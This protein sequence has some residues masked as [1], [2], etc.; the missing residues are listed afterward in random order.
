[1]KSS[2]ILD[3]IVLALIVGTAGMLAGAPTAA[4]AQDL[5]ISQSPLFVATNVEPNVMF[6]LDDSGSMQWEYMPDGPEFRFTIF[7]FPRPAGLY[8]GTN[9]A[10]QVPS[11]RDDNI[12]HLYARSA[13][14]NGVFY[15]PDITYRPWSRPDG[16]DMPPAD[17]ENALYNPDI[18]G[19]GGLNLTVPQTQEA[20]WFRGNAL[21]QGFCDGA[22][23]SSR[24]FTPITYFN[25]LGG[26]RGLLSSYDKVEIR[27]DTTPASATFTSPGGVTRTRDEEIQNFANWFQYH[28][29]RV[30]TS[31]GA[32]GNAFTEMPDQARVGFAAINQGSSSIDGV[33]HRAILRPVRPFSIAGREAFYDELYGRVINNFGTPLRQAAEA[34]GGYFERTDALGPWSTSPG[35]S[36]G[37]DLACRQSFHIMMSDGF[38]N[39]GNPSVGDADGTAGATI[40]GPDL[41][42]GAQSYQYQPVA[43]FADASRTNTL[44][45]VA[46]HY[47]KRDLRPDITNRVSTTPEDPAFWQ[48]LASFGIGLGVEGNVNPDDA[49]AAIDTQTPVNWGDPYN[50]NA[51]KIDDL[52]HFGLNG[53][54]GFFSAAD[55]Q[56]FADE[57]AAILTEIVA[58]TSATTGLSVSTTRLTEGSIIYAA[59]FDSEDWSGNVKAIDVFSGSTAWE[60]GPQLDARS[61]GG[62]R[63]LTSRN[64]GS[65]GQDFDI[66][67]QPQL[68]NA[69]STDAALANDVINYVRGDRSKEQ[70]N[71]G[72][73]RERSTVLADIVNS[74]PVYAG[75]GNEGWARL[76]GAAGSSYPDFVDD[77]ADET[78]AVYVG[79]NG[80]MLHAFD[81]ESGRELFAFVPRAVL[82]NL[83][84]L[85]NPNYGHKFF[86]DGQMVVRDAYAGGWKRVLVGGLGAGGRG[87]FALDVTDPDSPSVLWE[88]TGDDEPNL[89]YTFGDPVIT[90]LGNGQWVALFGNGYNSD[91]NNA[92][93]FVVDLFSGNVLHEIELE[94]GSDSNGLSGVA[95]LLNPLTRQS[96]SRAY[97]GDLNGTVWRVDFNES[98]APT[99]KY[100][101]GLFDDPDGRAI[102]ATPGLAASPA[103]GLVVYVGTGKLIEPADRLV[104]GTGIEKL[105]AL[106]DQDSRIGNNP[107]FGEPTITQSG[108]D[109]IIDG[110]AG[111]DGWVLELTP[112]GS[113]TGERVLSRPRI[114]FGQVIFSTFEPEDDPCAPGGFQRLYVVDALTGGGALDNICPNCGVVEVGIGAPIDPPIIIKPPSL[115][116]GNT[117]P[118][119]PNNPFDPD[120]DMP[121]PG[122]VGSRDGW[123]SEFGTLNPATGQPL[124]IGT[125]CDGR[126]VWRQAR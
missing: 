108:G 77:K 1:M 125:I 21:D 12:H 115:G 33:N 65:G 87:I 51:A 123:C 36:G 107:G 43:P 126:Q 69:I 25:Y 124:L 42:Q 80:G 109:R 2:T 102:T 122:S 57:L 59:E 113:A 119:D 17:P 121:D 48:H 18:P 20:V 24:T 40:T 112:T 46:M 44:A 66:S 95:P 53:R 8:G 5:N 10:N 118:D 96:I 105:Y 72:P 91:D 3:K 99:V 68:R 60:A 71:G 64:S 4:Q 79:G 70:Q 93:L 85:A 32:I 94:T 117:D 98:G 61:P 111:E 83:K 38:W 11:F 76:P 88:I 74:R 13:A 22:C 104:G 55:P 110:E 29:S 116:T 28:R 31:R 14:N 63:I 26:P 15:N 27:V 101:Q 67:M 62:R 90:R 16:S 106:R 75:A 114:I 100:S 92:V 78:K 50:S 49:F 47:W 34:V 82:P 97:A 84:D 39:G 23:G 81:A 120:G 54:G 52:L 103:G 86:V 58:R 30:L 6:T 41:G 9:Y 7:M 56:T 35:S 73:F 45:D 19:L 89:G 37:E